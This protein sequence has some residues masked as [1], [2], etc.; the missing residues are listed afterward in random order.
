MAASSR[1]TRA[2]EDNLKYGFRHYGLEL[3][4]G[5]LFRATNESRRRG[6]GE[7]IEEGDG[8]VIESRGVKKRHHKVETD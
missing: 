8:A 3:R 4:N 2:R 7:G 1:A 5:E 6:A